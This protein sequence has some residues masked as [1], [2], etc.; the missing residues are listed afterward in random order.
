MSHFVN[1]RKSLIALA[2]AVALVA[3]VVPTC[4]MVGC[5]MEN[6][7]MGFMHAG[8]ELGLFGSCGGEYTSTA[9]PE[10]VIPPGGQSLLL[11]LFAALAAVAVVF[12]PQLVS[13]PV[14]LVEATLPPPPEDPLGARFRV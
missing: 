12:M 11:S 4:R 8:S 7:Y 3:I 2:I 9:G 5:S 10:G 13:R 1:S 6:G 14:Y